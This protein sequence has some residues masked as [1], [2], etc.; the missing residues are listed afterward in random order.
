MFNR[1]NHHGVAAALLPFRPDGRIALKHQHHL[2][3]TH[4]A[5]LTNMM[6][7]DTGYVNYLTD[8]EKRQV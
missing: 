2:Q 1:P 7:M 5:G 8:A 3:A 4:Q 6:N